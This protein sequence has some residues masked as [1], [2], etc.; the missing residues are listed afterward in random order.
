VG[1][2]LLLIAKFLPGAGALSTVMAGL[3]RTSFPRFLAY[4]LAGSLLW[5]GSA[6]ILGMVFN[7]MVGTLLDVL[8]EYGRVGVAFIVLA[9][10]LYMAFQWLQRRRLL[11]RLGV[12]PRTTVEELT[13]W[14]ESGK[15][16]VLVDV[17]PE[18]V[19]RIPGAIVF[20]LRSPLHTLDVGEPSANIVVYCACPNEVSAAILVERLRAAGFENTWALQGGYDALVE[21]ARSRTV[22]ANP[23]DVPAA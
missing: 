2:R 23:C 5:G 14:N 15:T 13:Q 9:L 10:A 17:R 7:K 1:P 21:S 12:I 3:T 20:D 11:K 6:L 18:A 19:D 22:I 8:S 16:T 4:D